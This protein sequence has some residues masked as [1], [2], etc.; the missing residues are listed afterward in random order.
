MAFRFEDSPALEASGKALAADSKA[1]A[2]SGKALAT[3]AGAS[4]MP[5]PLG[6]AARLAGVDT[7]SPAGAT[8]E[9]WY[10]LAR[11]IPGVKSPPGGSQRH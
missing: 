11:A 10:Q 4:G 8:G 3:V 2:A 1:L 6:L 5:L 9:G 7:W